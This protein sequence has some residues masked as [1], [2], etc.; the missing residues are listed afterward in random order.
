MHILY[1]DDD[2]DDREFFREA[3]REIDPSFTCYTANDG[4]EGLREMQEMIVMPDLIFVDMNMPV[5][6]G[7]QFLSEI[8]SRMRFRCIP[9]V[10][11]S[12]TIHPNDKKKFLAMGAQAVL[13]KPD[14]VKKVV[15]LIQSVIRENG[16]LSESVRSIQ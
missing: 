9:V 8:K 11:Y 4:A 15:H 10:I 14:S 2:P 3:V 12:T 13:V 5:M 16:V 7:K 1:I 6:N